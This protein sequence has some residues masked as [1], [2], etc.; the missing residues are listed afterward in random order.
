MKLIIFNEADLLTSVTTI[1][2]SLERIEA[3]H[4]TRYAAGGAD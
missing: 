3:I 1:Q 2:E 4:N